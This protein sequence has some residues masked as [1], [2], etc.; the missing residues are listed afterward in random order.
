MRIKMKSDIDLGIRGAWLGIILNLGLTILKAIAGIFSNSKAMLA[1]AFHSAS[2]IIASTVV[3]FSLKISRKPADKCH[4]YGHGKAE[5]IAA[6]TVGIILIFAGINIING[7][8][9]AIIKGSITPP[10]SFALWAA[11][12][13][14]IVKEGLFQYKYRVGNAIRSKALI[15]NAWEHRSDAYSS[16]AALIGIAGAKLGYEFGYSKLILA[17]SIAGIVVSIFVIKMGWNII[18]EATDE[19]MDKAID[20][21]ILDKIATV[22][23]EVNGVDELHEVRARFTGP[24]LL[25][26]LKIGVDSEKTVKQGHDIATDV[27][28]LIFEKIP[29]VEDV[30]VH[31]NPKRNLEKRS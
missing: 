31:V 4:P 24:K 17:D 7:S 30:L 13:S 20:R 21:E 12:I 25:I 22:V 26:D 16:I 11:I 5:A 9:S 18:K 15:A 27:K 8:F 19:L 6:K 28:R 29:N 3:L 14:I 23:R 10:G 2:D 1:D